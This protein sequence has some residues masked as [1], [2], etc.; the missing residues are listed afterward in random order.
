MYIQ[1]LCEADRLLF[2]QYQS[3]IWL[4][5]GHASDPSLE[6]DKEMRKLAHTLDFPT[7]LSLS[8]S[9]SPLQCTVA[10]WLAGTTETQWH[11]A[12]TNVNLWWK[13]MADCFLLLK[14]YSVGG[15]AEKV[16]ASNKK[17]ATAE[18]SSDVME[19]LTPVPTVTYVMPTSGG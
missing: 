11:R 8:L 17:C 5:Q 15:G 10:D 18:V 12:G 13:T 6:D 2:I 9:V 4:L 1:W 3:G 7:P 19:Y 16:V 14:H